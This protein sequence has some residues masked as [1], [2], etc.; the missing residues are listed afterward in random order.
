MEADILFYKRYMV[1]HM[2]DRADR[3]HA[4]TEIT[5]KNAEALCDATDI[6]WYRVFGPFK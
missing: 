1:W 3:I 6:C 2:L 5:S 4:A